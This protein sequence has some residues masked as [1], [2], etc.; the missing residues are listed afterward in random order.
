V[1]RIE[2][3]DENDMFTVE[4][5]GYEEL[6]TTQKRDV[7]LLNIEA[8]KWGVQKRVRWDKDFNKM[9]HEF[10]LV[11]GLIK[12]K[13]VQKIIEEGSEEVEIGGLPPSV[14]RKKWIQRE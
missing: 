3:H 11:K 6:V 14:G 2:L 7:E 12:R 1:D 4:I 10:E 5:P 13:I 8:A 9:L